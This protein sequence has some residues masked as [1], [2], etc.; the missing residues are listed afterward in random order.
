MRRSRTAAVFMTLVIGSVMGCR[1]KEIPIGALTTVSGPY[2]VNGAFVQ[3]GCE[4]AFSECNAAGGINGH[5][6]K[7]VLADT[8]LDDLACTLAAQH[9]VG[10]DKVVAVLGPEFSGLA[11]TGGRVCQRAQIPLVATGASRP[12]VTQVGDYVFRAGYVD[13]QQGEAGARFA[14]ETLKARNAACLFKQYFGNPVFKTVAETFAAKFSSLGGKVVSDYFGKDGKDPSHMLGSLL[15]AKPDLLYLAV[16][17]DDV[18][19]LARQA[20]ERGFSGPILGVDT[21]DMPQLFEG[22]GAAV[23]GS[24][25]TDSFC[26]DEPRPAVQEFA[27]NY[28]ARFGTE[29]NADAAIAYDAARLVFDSLRRAG[30]TKG[31]AVRDALKAADFPGIAGKVKFDDFRNPLKPVLIVQVRSGRFAYV[32]TVGP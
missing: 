30:S 16:D 14:Y 11:V 25:F 24:Y 18:P 32:A 23:E 5:P 12:E 2:A 1:K 4:L 10:Q 28:R 6:V 29:P 8:K 13:Q 21:W 9:L 27:K 22:G 19:A 20:R 15:A 26:P 3:H 17:G 31:S 7:L